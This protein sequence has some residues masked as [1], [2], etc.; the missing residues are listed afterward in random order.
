M[1][2]KHFLT[3]AVNTHLYH[4]EEDIIRNGLVG[5]K[6]AVRYLLGL[7]DMLEGT[8]NQDVKATVKWDGAPAIVCGKDPLNGKF[9]VG[10]KAVFNSR[11]PKVNYTFEDI[12][13]NHPDQGLNKKLKYALRYLGKLNITGVVQGDLMFTPGDLKPERID[14]EAFL[15]F[16]PNTITYAVQKGSKLYNQV[17]K[18]KIGIVFHTK[19]DGD[20]IDTLSASFGVDV[21]DFGQ[22]ADVWYD[23]AY[24]K[25]YSGTATFKANESLGLKTAIKKIDQL[26]DEVPMPLWMKL[27]TNKDFVQYMLQFINTQIKQGKVTQDPKQMMQQYINYYRDIQAQAKDKL[28]TDTAKSKRD[29]AVAVMGKLFA[30][31]ERG[32]SA[33]IRIHNATMQIKNKIIAQINSV[34]ST[35]QFIKTDQGYKVTSPEGYVAIDNDGQAVKLVDRLVFS[36]ANFSAQKQWSQETQAS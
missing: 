31:N 18:A 1:R 19:Y 13:R 32:V 4:I 26:V 14:D 7:V 22:N 10:T 15:T 6:S 9:F 3:E 34:Q 5:A 27:S 23:D 2:I 8:G 20:T 17:T 12:D 28:K 36:K 21:S 33:I 35:K 11:T 29:Q 16:T 25:D 30:E 24:F